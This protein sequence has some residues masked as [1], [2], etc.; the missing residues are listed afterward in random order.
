MA[1]KNV[2]EV[3]V[4]PVV[5]TVDDNQE[6][7]VYVPVASSDVA[8][9]VKPDAGDFS[10]ADD[11]KLSLIKGDS[12]DSLQDALDTVAQVAPDEIIRVVKVGSVE[13]IDWADFENGAKLLAAV[14][15]ALGREDTP[16]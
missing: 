16:C 4:T 5:P 14:I 9:A 10:V 2:T 1:E 8:S 15:C 3:L 13:V 7:T 6:L 11:G 12:Y